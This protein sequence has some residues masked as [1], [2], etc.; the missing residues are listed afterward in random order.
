MKIPLEAV[1]D[2]ELLSEVARR[3]LD[4]RENINESLVAE[5]YDMGKQQHIQQCISRRIRWL[6]I[7]M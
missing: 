6:H 3:N 1:T 4:I 7:S 5:A 2:T